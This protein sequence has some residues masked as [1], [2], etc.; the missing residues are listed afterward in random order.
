MLAI[1]YTFAGHNYVKFY[2]GGKADFL[3]LAASINQLCNSNRSCPQVLEGWQ[4]S[5]GGRDGLR[6]GSMLYFP[7]AREGD[8]KS[9]NSNEYSEFT[10]IYSFFLPDH[11]FEAQGGVGKSVTSGWKNRET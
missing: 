11:W 4:A 6:K 10:L 9:A 3:E 8:E 1:L 7:A 5:S 2:F